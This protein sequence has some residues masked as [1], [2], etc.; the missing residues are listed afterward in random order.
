MD[1]CLYHGTFKYQG[2]TLNCPLI[3]VSLNLALVENSKLFFFHTVTVYDIFGLHTE[4]CRLFKTNIAFPFPLR[5][6]NRNQ[7]AN[8]ANLSDL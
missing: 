2:H 6:A 1:S 4:D 3:A 5:G 8:Q 7:A